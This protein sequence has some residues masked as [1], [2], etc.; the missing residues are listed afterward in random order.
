MQHPTALFSSFFLLSRSIKDFRVLN[1]SCKYINTKSLECIAL[2]N[3]SKNGI[4]AEKNLEKCLNDYK[5]KILYDAP[6][7]ISTEH[8]TF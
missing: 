7:T 3:L 2:I 4:L 8:L 6:K 1:S 5:F